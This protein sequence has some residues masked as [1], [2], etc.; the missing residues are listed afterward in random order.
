MISSLLAAVATFV[1]PDLSLDN[2]KDRLVSCVTNLDGETCRY[3]TLTN[4]GCTTPWKLDTGFRATT[5]AFAVTPGRDFA[6]TA[7]VRG[8]YNLRFARGAMEC[9]VDWLDATGAKTG[10]PFHFGLDVGAS[11]WR[12][13]RACGTVPAGAASAKVTL[14]ADEPNFRTGQ[15]LAL[16][17]VSFADYP[18]GA[19]PADSE[20]LPEE[21]YGPP[22]TQEEMTYADD[23]ISPSGF[24]L[25]DGRPFFPIGI[26][27]V[28]KSEHNG[29][30]FD[31]AFDELKRC[32]FNTVQTYRTTRGPEFAAFLDAAD[33]HG[34]KVFVAPG[35]DN[36]YTNGLTA[37]IL[38]E[39]RHDC[40]LAWYIA[41]D[42][43]QH[44]I[45][46]AL[47][48][49][50]AKCHALDPRRLTAQADGVGPSYLSKYAPFV[51]A[52]DVFLPE[53][54][55]VTLERPDGTEVP[56]VVRDMKTIAADI[57]AHPGR[58][59]SV[60]P[61]IQHF[62]GWG[63]WK[64]FPTFDELRAMSYLAVIHGANGITWYTYSVS[65]RGKGAPATPEHWR[66][67]TTVSKELAAISDDLVCPNAA[68]QPA[69]TVTSGP[70]KDALG[71]DSVSV[72]VKESPKGNLLLA[73]NSST[74]AVRATI[75][76]AHPLTLDFAPYGVR[77]IRL[78]DVTCH[79]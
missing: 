59:K 13:A 58:R 24:P 77:V 65:N 61:I 40:L 25:V 72:L 34:L 64:R 15:W 26:Y 49:L 36:A 78:N 62:E 41:D 6:V 2:Y 1:A 18:S 45:P 33:R 14:G 74:N 35:P 30:D 79:P 69:V 29:Q 39:K 17:S 44:T 53:I 52:T 3:L 71:F 21:F 73:A 23:K 63:A 31:R 57:K 70:R 38:S 67:L 11:R 60:W 66:E 10:D 20:P 56:H 55:P 5:P 4:A 48:T 22:L 68:V 28:W 16:A 50:S 47:R 54:Y 42:T 51:D 9:K 8:T 43:S 27:G 46:A 32:G 12:N 19:V 37:N 75:A 76:L 7:R